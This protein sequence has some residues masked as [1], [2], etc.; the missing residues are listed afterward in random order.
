MAKPKE[1][2][3]S[4][5]LGTLCSIEKD[6]KYLPAILT[7]IAVNITKLHL[8]LYSYTVTYFKKTKRKTIEGDWIISGYD[9]GIGRFESVYPPMENVDYSNLRLTHPQARG[10][11][12]GTHLSCSK[13]F[14]DYEVLLNQAWKIMDNTIGKHIISLSQWDATQIGECISAEV[15]FDSIGN[16]RIWFRTEKFTNTISLPQIFQ[17]RSSIPWKEKIRKQL[18]IIQSGIRELFRAYPELALND[19]NA[20]VFQNPK[21]RAYRYIG[22]G[23]E[24]HRSSSPSLKKYVSIYHAL[25]DKAPKQF[26][27]LKEFS[28][29]NY[30]VT[31]GNY[32][33]PWS[34]ITEEIRKFY[35]IISDHRGEKLENA[36]LWTK[37][38]KMMD[39]SIENLLLL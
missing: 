5:G 25:L 9:S 2:L 32:G 4:I 27:R 34:F 7:G 21:D 31:I 14:K 19:I 24:V 30:P 11:Y 28:E 37:V 33:N 16:G 3:I 29:Y 22:R 10:R 17:E 23:L 39:H 13:R 6:K 35:N 8:P 36:S 26:M 12:T 18:G 1:A 15:A 20:P 38:K